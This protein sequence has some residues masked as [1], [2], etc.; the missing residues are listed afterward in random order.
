MARK[1]VPSVSTD[2]ETRLNRLRIERATL[3]AQEMQSRLAG[4]S[5][6]ARTRQQLEQKEAELAEELF[7]NLPV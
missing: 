6:S 5:A 1:D 3:M 7:D 4:R 2:K